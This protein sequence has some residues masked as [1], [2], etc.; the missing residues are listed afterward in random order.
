MTA[1][2]R[3]GTVQVVNGSPAVVGTLTA[4][5]NQVNGGDAISFDAGETW[6]EI[7]SVEDNTHLTLATNYVGPGDVGLDYAIQRRSSQWVLA[8]ET[9]TKVGELLSRSTF[10][11][12]GYGAPSSALGANGSLYIDELD[13]QLY[14][15]K[16]DGDWGAPRSLIS[17]FNPDATGTFA[18]RAAYDDEAA[19]FSF[20]ST[21]GDGGSIL[22]AVIFIK[23]TGSPAAW[24]DPIPF[25]GP[26]G[27]SG[28]GDKYTIA[29]GIN[30]RPGAGEILLRHEFE[31]SVSF[32]ADLEGSRASADTPAAAPAEFSVTKN[33]FEVGTITFPYP[34]GDVGT[35]DTG[36][37]PVAFV[38][39]DIIRIIAPAVRD[40]ALANISLTLAGQ[41]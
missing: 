9:A 18:E 6:Y 10:I 32:P 5:L 36:G 3:T 8:T 4:W 11:L 20:L 17:N 22:T 7:S 21:D 2:Y 27:P 38:A 31:V 29:C 34:D 24:S 23:Q 37:N 28:V 26:Q 13:L 16:A 33:G 39:G 15:P 35:F 19:G 12:R 1:W 14:G 25:E 30:G 41:R 40:T